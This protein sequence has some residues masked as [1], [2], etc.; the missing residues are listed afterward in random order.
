M[1][2]AQSGARKQ[3]SALNGPGAGPGGGPGEGEGCGEGHGSGEGG[4]ADMEPQ[5]SALPRVVLGYGSKNT[6]GGSVEQIRG[7]GNKNTRFTY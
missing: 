7:L 3:G 5:R 2:A 6:E 1:G 4:S